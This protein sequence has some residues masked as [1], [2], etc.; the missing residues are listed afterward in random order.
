MLRVP[1]FMCTIAAAKVVIALAKSYQYAEKE[2]FRF[3][4]GWN[5]AVSSLCVYIGAGTLNMM[6]ETL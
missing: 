6:H 4:K 5:R 1:L 3:Q 2:Q